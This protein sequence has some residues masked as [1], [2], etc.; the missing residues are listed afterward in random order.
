MKKI[1][2]QGLLLL[3]VL[4]N[5]T[6]AQNNIPTGATGPAPAVARPLP[7]NDEPSKNYLRV[8]SPVVPIQDMDKVTI[9][10]TVDSVLATTQYFDEL[11]RPLQK[12]IKQAS[13]LKKDNVL[14]NYYDEF[15]RSS[16]QYLPYVAQT[17]NY[18]DGKF[19]TAA[20]AADSAFNK[21]MYPNEQVYYAQQQY[22]G[23]PLNRVT[24][25]TTVGNSFTGAG[26]GISQSWR[27][28]TAADSVVLWTVAIT[29][30]D[31]VP[32]KWGLY[33]AGSLMLQQTIDER[34]IKTIT[35]VDENG[36]TILTKKQ[37]ANSPSTGHYGW[38]CTYYVYDEMNHLRLVN[39]RQ[40]KH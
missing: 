21:S 23:S 14:L 29:S 27:A 30:E 5:V 7:Y 16:T 39:L 26:I 3:F 40:P 18:D 24:K 20:F 10:S 15:S 2:L 35:Y 9:T 25:T 6:K 4:T 33:A 1:L 12:V 17:A 38:L 8:L 22:D 28:N 36:K 31:D 34:G 19:K 32:V 11:H 37:L 13:P